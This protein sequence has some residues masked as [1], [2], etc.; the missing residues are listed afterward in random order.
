MPPKQKDY[1]MKE[2]QNKKH[3]NVSHKIIRIQPAGKKKHFT[4]K[5]I[6]KMYKELKDSGIRANDIS[7]NVMGLE[8]NLTLK[9]YNNDSFYDMDEYYRD[10]VEDPSKFDHYDYLDITIKKRRK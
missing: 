7:I 1:T 2:L 3:K 9:A 10:K 5:D 6:E 8:R 4:E